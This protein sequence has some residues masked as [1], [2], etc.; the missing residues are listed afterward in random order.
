[1]DCMG[2]D[3]FM[4]GSLLK[5]P[6]KV[7]IK[8]GTSSIIPIS[9][10]TAKQSGL[11]SPLSWVFFSK[12]V[13]GTGAYGACKA[14]NGPKNLAKIFS[15]KHSNECKALNTKSFIS[16]LGIMAILPSISGG[17]FFSKG[18]KKTSKNKFMPYKSRGSGEL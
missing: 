12:V 4:T 1:M 7:P 17:D 16:S 5:W 3:W 14:L 9:C 2:V 18:T 11:L 8:L 13:M 10:I 15:S 6:M